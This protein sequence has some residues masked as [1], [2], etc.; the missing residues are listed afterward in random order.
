MAK[1]RSRTVK[2]PT[3]RWQSDVIVGMIKRY[4]F[5]YIA[6]NGRLPRVTRR[7]L[8][9]YGE[10]DSADAAAPSTKRSLPDRFAA[11]L[12]PQGSR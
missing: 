6:L 3:R 7:R 11:M 2:N 10:N 5:R 1:P 8:V 4:G 9:N 12:A